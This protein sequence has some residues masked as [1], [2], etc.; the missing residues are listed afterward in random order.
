MM[1]QPA[2]RYIGLDIANGTLRGA[3]V[4][5]AGR[6]LARNDQPLAKTSVEIL[7][8]QL[9][10]AVHAVDGT[11]SEAA[12]AVGI[13]IPGV[14]TGN[15]VSMSANLSLLNGVP[16]A[17]ELTRRLGRPA[18]LEND[19][20]AAALAEAWQGAGRGGKSVLYISLGQG[21]GSGLVMNS[22]IWAGPNG[23]AGEIG[24]VQV[25]PAGAPCGC[26]L[27]GCL[28][29]IAGAAGWVRRAKTAM[30]NR[31]TKLQALNLDQAAILKAAEEGDGVALEVMDETARA[32]GITLA[33]AI[34]LL[35]LDRVVI[36]GPAASSMLL[37]R[38]VIE[39][40][41]RTLPRAFA[42]CQIKLSELNDGACVLGAARVARTGTRFGSAPS[43]YR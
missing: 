8:N 22:Q 34:G 32:L 24:H 26:G 43:E 5:V 1:H 33:A 20:N 23:Y 39:A 21:I 28:E 37:E 4:N 36:G 6:S 38:V 25:E 42:E 10:S 31:P 7:V 19:A 41:Q 40:R 27:R 11:G 12:S 3:R 2:A 17:D 30:K 15:K 16:L 18:M 9:V 14:V 13:A 29:T 35:N